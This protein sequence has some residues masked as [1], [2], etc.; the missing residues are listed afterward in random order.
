VDLV[1][2]IEQRYEVVVAASV[3]LDE[4][5]VKLELADGRRWVAR[6]FSAQRPL[7]TTEAEAALLKRLEQVG[8]PAERCAD[9]RPVS[10]CAGRPV[11][12]T[13]F[14]D[15]PRAGSFA[16]LG[17]LLGGLHARPGTGLPAGG[18]WH[19]VAVGTPADE[20]TAVSELLDEAVSDVGAR[21][22]ARLDRLRAAAE[23]AD[24]C[25]DLPHCVVHPDFVP[26]N[27]IRGEHGPVIVDW[28]GAGRGPRL[29]SLGFLLWA[30]ASRSR[31][32]AVISRY[33]RRVTL[34]PEEL[35]RLEGALWGRP[36]MLDCWSFATGRTPL[37]YAAERVEQAQLD[38][39][40]IAADARRL[41]GG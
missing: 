23:R 34:E 35:D 32:E 39:R 38:A 18:A 1:G 19:H 16:W 4:G 25:H 2:H 21:E 9:E 41:F 13:E 37:A 12:V 5:T 20:I 33:T 17:A 7:A 15:G 11:L 30:A 14:I 26:A 31:L 3:D 28:A 40:R 27:A 36:V 29:W 24:D 8:F 10:S 22:L 6:I